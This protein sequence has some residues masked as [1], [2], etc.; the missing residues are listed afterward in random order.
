MNVLWIPWIIIVIIGLIIGIVYSGLAIK[1]ALKPVKILKFTYFRPTLC[2]GRGKLIEKQC[3]NE[4]NSIGY[5]IIDWLNKPSND[6]LCS[7][8]ITNG[9]VTQKNTDLRLFTE[10][11]WIT[12]RYKNDF[13]TFGAIRWSSLYSQKIDP[14]DPTKTTLTYLES[15]VAATTGPFLEYKSGQVL[16]DYR[17]PDRYIYVFP[18]NYNLNV[19]KFLNIT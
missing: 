9:S 18:N 2:H 1:K 5:G 3:L 8:F 15:L 10:N 19:K 16:F 13:K 17:T 4:I 6:I 14:K 12:M 7:L 11:Y